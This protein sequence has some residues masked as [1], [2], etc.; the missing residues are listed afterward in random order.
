MRAFIC[1]S[2]VIL[3]L[4]LLRFAFPEAYKKSVGYAEL[5]YVTLRNGQIDKEDNDTFQLQS[6]VAHAGGGIDNV[7]RANSL[8]A[9]NLSYGKGFRFIELDFEW[10]TDGHLVL[11][12]DWKA[13]FSN[14]FNTTPR[15]CSLR[16]YKNLRMTNGMTNLS[17]DEL[18]GWIKRHPDVFIITDVKH[19]NIRAL[20]KIREDFP[21]LVRNF[22]P[23]IYHFSEY[24]PVHDLGYQHII[25]TLYVGAYSDGPLLKFARKYPLAAVTMPIGRALTDL[26]AKLR[27]LGV[28]T[29]AH[30]VNE[31]TLQRE[32]HANEV[33]GVYTDFLTP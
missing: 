7:C 30:T 19:D 17:L 27:K 15:R 14:L 22:I 11:I 21:E 24:S 18:A 29:Y 4:L 32:L 1:G 2:I 23:Q 25:I 12:H 28:P 20:T 5:A 33:F 16:E 6:L 8:E 9:L 26:P 31:V 13:T 3:S 10:T